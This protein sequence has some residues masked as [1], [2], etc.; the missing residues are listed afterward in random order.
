MRGRKRQELLACLLEAR[1]RGRSEMARLELLDT[2]YPQVP[3]GQANSALKELVH[4]TRAALGAAVIQTTEGGYAL[5][6]VATDAE[7]F[8]TCGDT[9]LWRGTYL[10]GIQLDSDDLIRE[11]LYQALYTQALALLETDTPEAVRLG[12]L[13]HD[14]DPYDGAAL[15]MLLRA[16]QVAGNHR[17]LGRVYRAA[18]K[19]WLELGEVLP[20]D[21]HAFL[22]DQTKPD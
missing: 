6:E 22:A 4:Q 10:A 17:T 19:Q 2:L 5:G 3:E 12:R 8:L 1:L 14:A 18:Q 16:L 11:T 21:W 15:A 9:H 13:L 7:Q 20:D